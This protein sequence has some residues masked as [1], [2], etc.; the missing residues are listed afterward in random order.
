MF[1]RPAGLVYILDFLSVCLRVPHGNSM[2]ESPNKKI[3]VNGLYHVNKPVR[4]VN[5]WLVV[6]VVTV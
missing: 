2:I 3:L 4:W 5:E 6:Y 1:T